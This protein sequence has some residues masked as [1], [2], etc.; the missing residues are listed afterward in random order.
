MFK[1]PTSGF[2]LLFLFWVAGSQWPPGPDNQKVN[3]FQQIREK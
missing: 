1:L 2:W 3:N